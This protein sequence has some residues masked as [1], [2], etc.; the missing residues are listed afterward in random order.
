MQ[1][2]QRAQSTPVEAVSL[3]CQSSHLLQSLSMHFQVSSVKYHAAKAL[4]IAK[5]NAE[6]E[7]G[8]ELCRSRKQ[9]ISFG[10]K[11]GYELN[12]VPQY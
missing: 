9:K 11:W 5:T 12:C 8:V 4:G 10:Q 7:E 2:P 3:R 1:M 6:I